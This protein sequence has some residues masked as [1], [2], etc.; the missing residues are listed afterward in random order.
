M[1]EPIGRHLVWVPFSMRLGWRYHSSKSELEAFAHI[2]REERE[3][4]LFERL[5]KILLYADRHVTFYRRHYRNHGYDPASF[6]KLEDWKNVPIVTKS[7]L[8]GVDFE[9]RLSDN[10][11]GL[12]INT[13]GTS[14]SP[15]EFYIDRHAF[16]RE[17]AH[18][19]HIWMKRGYRPHHLK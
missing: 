6:R 14:G 9:N 8:K 16:S 19:H 4:R 12:K 5:R 7:D 15:L 3:K 1:P 18:M 10:C 11:S 17:W 2:S 13:G